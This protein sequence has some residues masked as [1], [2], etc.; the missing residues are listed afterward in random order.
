[1]QDRS[2]DV[3]CLLET[4]KRRVPYFVRDDNIFSL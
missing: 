4:K 2:G 3:R 1:V